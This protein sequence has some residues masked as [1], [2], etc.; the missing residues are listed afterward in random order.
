MPS[1]LEEIILGVRED[2]AQRRLAVPEADLQSRA[3]RARAARP[4]HEA[5]R[6]RDQVHVIAEVKRASP[7]RGPLAPHLDPAEL[8]SQYAAGGASVVSV[9][10]ER[11]R[12]DG[13]LE[14]LDAVR[15]S[16]DLPVLRKDFVVEDYQVTEARAH[17]AD[18]LL[19]I[20]AALD[21]PELERLMALTRSWGM[22][23]LVEVHDERELDRAM[24]AGATVIGV[25]NRDLATLRVDRD[26]FARVAAH[27]PPEAILVAES[28]IRDVSDV[29]A[30]RAAG[31]DAVLVGETLVTGGRPRDAVAELVAAGLP[32]VVGAAG[33]RSR[34]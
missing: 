4:A 10:T 15:G 9:L 32:A 26:T 17:G 28:G 12:F 29:A 18:L 34:A 22:E 13:S 30:A 20:V 23:A 24:S 1:V 6:R 7:S 25:N 31:A 33:R 19:L 14:D 16:C 21:D 11:R 8:A 3:S 27:A 5:L 2:T